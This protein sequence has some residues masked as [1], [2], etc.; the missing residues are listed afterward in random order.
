[1]PRGKIEK[2]INREKAVMTGF[3]PGQPPPLLLLVPA[4]LLLITYNPTQA[5]PANSE[6]SSELSSRTEVAEWH[7][8]YNTSELAFPETG[9]YYQY[10]HYDEGDQIIT[11]EPCLNCTCHNQMLMCFL[12]VC[13]FI[14]PVG[15]NC[16]VEKKDNQ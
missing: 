12:R 2:L 10:R 6:L 11:N 15:Q 16:V 7:S 1:L 9:C 5:A 3:L 13:P 14:K 4:V 8:T